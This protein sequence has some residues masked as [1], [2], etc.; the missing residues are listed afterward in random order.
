MRLRLILPILL[1]LLLSVTMFAGC[2]GEGKVDISGDVNAEGSDELSAEDIQAIR[3]MA[4]RRLLGS[5]GKRASGPH[6]P[7]RRGAIPDRSSC[8]LSGCYASVR[9]LTAGRPG[10]L[11]RWPPPVYYIEATAK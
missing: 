4:T 8:N 6:L 5:M 2:S 9:S 11:T 10:H 3:D 1:V 7:R